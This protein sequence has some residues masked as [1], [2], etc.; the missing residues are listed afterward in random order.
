M[1]EILNWTLMASS[2]IVLTLAIRTMLKDKINKVWINALWLMVLVRLLVPILPS[3]SMSLF[4][5]WQRI[6]PMSPT[7]SNPNTVVDSEIGTVPLHFMDDE[8]ILSEA[9]GS[10]QEKDILLE[11]NHLIKDINK[12]PNLLVLWFLG[13]IM[14]L[15]YFMIGY[16]QMKKKINQLEVVEDKETLALLA[17]LKEIL[18]I[19][20]EVK[21]LKG[22]YPFIFGLIR[23]VICL[24]N[25]FTRDEVKMM[26]LHELMHLKYRDNVLTYLHIV[27]LAIHWFNPL[28]WLAIRL[29]KHDMELVCD[30]RVLRMGTDKKQY[31]NTLLKIVLTPQKE[32]FWVQGMGENAKE[33]KRR[34]LLIATFKE[35]KVSVTIMG[36]ILLII[37]GILCLT[38][39]QQPASTEGIEILK[40]VGQQVNK[41]SQEEIWHNKNIKNIVVLGVDESQLLTDTIMVINLDKKQDTLKLISIP[42][43]TKVKWD[44]EEKAAV[45][46]VGVMVPDVT[47]INE[48]YAYAKGEMTDKLV[49][50]QIEKLLNIQVDDVIVVD[51]KAI[52]KVIDALGG[53]K[54]ELMQDMRYTDHA[55]GLYINL[56]KGQQQLNGKETLQAMRYRMYPDGDLGRINMQQQIVKTMLDKILAESNGAQLLQAASETL[57]GIKTSISLEDLPSYIQVLLAV[58]QNQVSFY[59]LPGEARYEEGRSYFIPDL[60]ESIEL[61]H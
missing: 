44:E 26:L 14:V 45:S 2:V 28:V 1:G 31:A 34:L 23:P 41:L 36:V 51:F 24:S 40:E 12:L 46:A 7:I 54:I 35:P 18:H 16:Y 17:E 3:S 59:T 50:N 61:V 20:A 10:S 4:N 33:I 29:M 38:N 57:S 60:K 48:M 27:G 13:M 47:K 30:E 42:R 9:E 25:S 52:E 58:K 56:K 43:D 49:L 55:A 21:L 8:I 5:L 11:N 19:K 53:V 15:G 32:V 22:E 6:D 37:G 39:A